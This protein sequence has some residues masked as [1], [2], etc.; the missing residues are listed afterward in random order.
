MKMIC[1]HS[2]AYL[3]DNKIIIPELHISSIQANP[4]PILTQ[5]APTHSSSQNHEIVEHLIENS[6]SSPQAG[7]IAGVTHDN[8]S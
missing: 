5:A 7:A 2:N 4:I 6:P 3:I 8:G 1:V